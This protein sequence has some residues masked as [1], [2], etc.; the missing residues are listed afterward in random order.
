MDLSDYDLDKSD[1]YNVAWGS[2]RK[3]EAFPR[4]NQD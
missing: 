2:Q 1:F 3:L 4:V